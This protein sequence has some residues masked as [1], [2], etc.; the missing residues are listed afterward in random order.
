VGWG[1]VGWG[2]VGWGGVGWGGVGW[3]GVGWGGVGFIT[4]CR[5]EAGHDIGKSINLLKVSQRSAAPLQRLSLGLRCLHQLQPNSAS[6]FMGCNLHLIHGTR[7][8]KCPGAKD[9][10]NSALVEVS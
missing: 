3:G 8:R 5:H 2:G 4:A 9:I 6:D 10:S 1:G 7:V